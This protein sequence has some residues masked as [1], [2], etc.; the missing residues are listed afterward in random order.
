MAST[1]PYIRD[2]TSSVLKRLSAATWCAPRFTE[3]TGVCQG[4]RALGY[5]LTVEELVAARD[6]GVGSGVPQSARRGGIPGPSL[7]QLIDMRDHGSRRSTAQRAPAL[8]ARL[9]RC[10]SRA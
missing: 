10:T 5:T 1:A 9:I 6:H 4:M 7:A 2:L 3:W 8:V